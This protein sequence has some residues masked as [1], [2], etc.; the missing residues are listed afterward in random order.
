M[1]E[2]EIEDIQ[3][4]VKLTNIVIFQQKWEHCFTGQDPI[5]FAG[6]L[7]RTFPGSFLAK[8]ST[9][10]AMVLHLI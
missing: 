6:R 3:I 1:T 7:S 10:G 9:A 8:V 2:I 5:C 4:I